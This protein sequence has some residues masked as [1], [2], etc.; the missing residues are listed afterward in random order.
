MTDTVVSMEFTVSRV[1]VGDVQVYPAPP[2]LDDV[3]A[4]LSETEFTNYMRWGASP[5]GVPEFVKWAVQQR[6][7]RKDVQHD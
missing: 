6:M 5:G 3:K 4:A 1:F 7:A 2:D